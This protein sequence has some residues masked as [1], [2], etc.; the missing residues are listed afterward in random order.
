MN[1]VSVVLVLINCMDGHNILLKLIKELH[2]TMVKVEENNK[3]LHTYGQ[4]LL[5]GRQ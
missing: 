1:G 5:I 3:M 2:V 4:I